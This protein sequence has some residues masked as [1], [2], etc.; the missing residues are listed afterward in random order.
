MQKEDILF[1]K[2][3]EGDWR[4]FNSFFNSYVDQLCN[5]AFGFVRC[6]EAAEDIVQ[7]AFIYLWENRAK[8]AYTGSVYA[9]LCRAVKNSCIDYKL[10]EKVEERYRQE[11]MMSGEVD[12][13]EDDNFEELY[14]R[15]Q[16]IMET[17][18]PKCKEVFVLGCIESMSYKEIADQ[19]DVSVNTVKTQMKTAYKKIKDELGDKDKR[20]MMILFV[21]L[22]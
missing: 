16:S 7:D 15:L 19:L 17:L 4:A 12:A 9:Y 1:R 21:S 2:M 10:H 20:F 14:E 8:I 11:M 22:E 5:Y 6:K 13:D 18:P 3:Q